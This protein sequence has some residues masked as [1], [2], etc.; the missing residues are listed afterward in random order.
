MKR[1]L[2]L[3]HYGAHQ[4]FQDFFSAIAKQGNYEVKVIIPKEIVYSYGYGTHRFPERKIINNVEYIPSALFDKYRYHF[5]GY[6]PELPKTILSFKPDTIIVTDEVYTL[7]AWFVVLYKFL[8]FKHYQI[9]TWSQANYLENRHTLVPAAQLILSLNKP[10]INK[11]IARNHTQSSRIK[12]V[13]PSSKHVQTV[14]WSS[15]PDRFQHLNIPRPELLKKLGITANLINKQLIGFAG[16][17]V[18]EKGVLDVIECLPQLE[19]QF[20]FLVVGEGKANYIEEIKQYLEEHQLKQRCILLGKKDYE[21]LLLFYNAID[22]LILPTNNHNNF[23]ELFGRVLAEAMMCKTLVLGSSNG[24]IPE[25]INNELC[26]FNQNDRIDMI[27]KIKHLLN[28]TSEQRNSLLEQQYQ[29]A[30]NNF[31]VTAF[32][33]NL[34]TLIER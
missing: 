9:I 1:I 8:F 11:F 23:Y 5:S 34:I 29:H 2:F 33:R 22:L 27:N 17:L 26:I 31:S 28:L 13:I 25:V 4:Q 30:I 24:G 15:H 19:G 6:F 16:R 21:E 14:Y 18:P 32:A 3:S 12:A 10:F 20:V 7:D